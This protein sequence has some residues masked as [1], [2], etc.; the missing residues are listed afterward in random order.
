MTA[1]RSANARTD[2]SD[3]AAMLSA[4]VVCLIVLPAH[5]QTGLAR[6]RIDPG[7]I[8]VS[9]I[10]SGG[11]MAVQLGVAYSSVFSGV[12]VVA[13]G[14]YGCADT[15]GSV[16]SNVIRAMGPC[17][18]GRYELLQR[19]QCAVGLA[20]CPGA[21]APDVDRSVQRARQK[22]AQ[23]HID[24]LAGLAR[25]RVF[26]LS[27]N[28]DRTVAAEVVDALA[29]FYRSFVPIVQIQQV[30]RAGLAH[31]FPTADFGGGNACAVSESPFVS[32]CDFDGAEHVLSHLYGPLAAPGA[33]VAATQ[34]V[35]FDQRPFNPAGTRSGMADSGYVYVP[36]SCT[37]DGSPVCG[38]HVA[39]HGCRQSAADVGMAFVDNAGYNRWA[40]T[41]RLI[42]LYPQVKRTEGFFSAN[43]K[44]CWDWWGYTGAGWDDKR[45]VQMRAIIAM[46]D[47]LKM[48]LP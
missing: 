16:H 18:A 24:P 48:P 10:S 41:N 37:A 42:V 30:R 35:E 13:A 25:Q 32:D 47:R 9:G 33:D 43:P 27:G 46:V 8:T 7:K 1:R 39:L 31:T 40:A 23:Q 36:S 21:N 45:S 19:W 20:S 22:E 26:L 3:A 2:A 11:Y 34:V 14:P 15:G 44:G 29:R 6:Y 38:L 12:G 17:M 28:E 5:A 4:L